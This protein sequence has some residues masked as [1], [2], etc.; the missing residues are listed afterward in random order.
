MGRIISLAQKKDVY[1]AIPNSYTV[2]GVVFNPSKIYA[3]QLARNQNY[4]LIVLNYPQEGVPSDFEYLISGMTFWK[5]VLT[6]HVL[7]TDYK[8]SGVFVNGAKI[9][10]GI[11]GDII[12]A[13]EALT[14]PTANG[15]RIF[16]P[17][18]DITALGFLGG[19]EDG[20]YD[21]VFTVNLYYPK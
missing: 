5:A 13:M 14:T 19:V 8:A 2:E 20:V 3:N 4:P 15:V 18:H 1:D 10:E 6:I 16:F 12:T 9:G 11:A 21:Y 17:N 7:A